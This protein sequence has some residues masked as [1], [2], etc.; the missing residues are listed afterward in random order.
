MVRP[1]AKAKQMTRHIGSTMT[2]PRPKRRCFG[3]ACYLYE[4]HEEYSLYSVLSLPDCSAVGLQELSI[5]QGIII[6][7]R[8]FPHNA[9]W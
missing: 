3:G 1:T 2:T 9:M 6:T 8:H 5:N 7:K 4:D